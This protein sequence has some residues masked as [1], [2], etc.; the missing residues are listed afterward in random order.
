GEVLH[1]ENADTLNYPASLTKMMTLYMV[2]DALKAKRLKL[3]DYLKVTD[4]AARQPASKLGLT[5]GA[6]ITVKQGIL[7]LTIKSAN[8]VAVAFA[9]TMAKDEREFALKMTAKARA[10]GMS[11]T[12]FR[13]ASGLPHR[14]QLSTARDMAVL[15]RAL[16]NNHAGYYHYFSEPEF[17]Y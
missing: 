14:G 16:L 2:F 4:R 17:T 15:A 11:S 1:E 5:P 12:T 7:A 3:G 6:K 8:D 9:E 13:N 10:L